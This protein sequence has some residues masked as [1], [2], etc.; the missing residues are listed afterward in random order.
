MNEDEAQGGGAA[1]ADGRGAP[2]GG[3][4]ARDD[5]HLRLCLLL[6]RPT[7]RGR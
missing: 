4:D 3:A 5:E 2:A 1:E 6:S 7:G